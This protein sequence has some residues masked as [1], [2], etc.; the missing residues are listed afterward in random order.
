LSKE[1]D[2]LKLTADL[3]PD[4]LD[5]PLKV[6]QKGFDTSSERRLMDFFLP[7]ELAVADSLCKDILIK[8]KA[9]A[10][11]RLPALTHLAST[12][13][14]LSL[15]LSPRD[16][17]D[18][19]AYQVWK[20]ILDFVDTPY[21]RGII[22]VQSTAGN[23]LSFSPLVGTKDGYLR[24]I[25]FWGGDKDSGVLPAYITTFQVHQQTGLPP[26]KVLLVTPERGVPLPAVTEI[27]VNKRAIR[28][29]EQALILICRL[30]H[31]RHEWLPNTRSCFRCNYAKG[32][33][34]SPCI[35]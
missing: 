23:L 6:F 25:F 32:E 33:N 26:D 15:S 10:L 24:I 1:N 4:L 17:K 34:A 12:S 29:A 35:Y 3:I 8:G 27:P 31:N 21:L 13:Q 22:N 20:T 30:W 16:I 9:V 14:S 18:D 5:C 7:P 19:P 28:R 2:L 11:Q